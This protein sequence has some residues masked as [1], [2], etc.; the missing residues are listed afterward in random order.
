GTGASAV[1]DTILQNNVGEIISKNCLVQN[2]GN[3]GGTGVVIVTTTRKSDAI[4]SGALGIGSSAAYSMSAAMW[5]FSTQPLGIR[6]IQLCIL[7]P[8][9]Q[10]ALNKGA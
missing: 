9:V 2:V 10:D 3:N 4:F 8:Q 6:P 5:G 7:D 1:W